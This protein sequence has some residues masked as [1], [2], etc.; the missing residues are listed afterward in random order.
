M[1]LSSPRSIPEPSTNERQ[2]L[3]C[4]RNNTPDGRFFQNFSLYSTEH[5]RQS[6]VR[7]SQSSE[8]D[9][10]LAALEPNDTKIHHHHH[11]KQT[12]NNS[13]ALNVPTKFT[14]TDTSSRRK[15]RP[16]TSSVTSIA[17]TNLHPAATNSYFAPQP[18]S[19]NLEARSPVLKRAPASRS[20]HGIETSS[21]PPPALS[22]QRSYTTEASRN[23]HAS[24]QQRP[25]KPRT[26]AGTLLVAANNIVAGD[27]GSRGCEV[28]TAASSRQK[29]FPVERTSNRMDRNDADV[30]AGDD[31]DATIRAVA[32]VGCGEYRIT[33]IEMLKL[34]IQ[35][36][37]SGNDDLFLRLARSNT[38]SQKAGDAAARSERRKSRIELGRHR[39]SLSTN[40]LP[41]SGARPSSSGR[42]FESR[43]STSFQTRPA[44]SDGWDRQQHSASSQA[45]SPKPDYRFLQLDGPSATSRVQSRNDSRSQ[46]QGVALQ[47]SFSAAHTVSNGS[48]SPESRNGRETLTPISKS[49]PMHAHSYRQSNLSYS[50]LGNGK[51][52]ELRGSIARTTGDESSP[53][54]PRADGTE[55]TASTTA[56]S[57][58]WDE[59]DDL[60]SRIRK[61]ELTGKLPT[62]SGEAVTNG[63]GERPPTA[64]TTV[65]TL[66]PSPKH[67]RGNS[68]SPSPSVVGGPAA[69][70]IH[71]LLHAS[72]AKAKPIIGS[73]AHRALEATA[74]DALSLATMMGSGGPQGT[75]SSAASI[76]GGSSLSERQ[77]R[78]KADS[79]CRSLTELCIAICDL[80]TESASTPARAQAVLQAPVLNPSA[81]P[82]HQ[83][84]DLLT[85]RRSHLES[86]DPDPSTLTRSGSRALSRLEARRSSMQALHTSTTAQSP[87]SEISTPTQDNLKRPKRHSLAPTLLPR[88]RA[89]VNEEDIND[90]EDSPLRPP[91]RALTSIGQPRNS[92]RTPREYTSR[93][94]LPNH[95]PPSALTNPQARRHHVSPSFAGSP[96]VPASPLIQSGARRYLERSTP[97]L[98]ERNP[99]PSSAVEDGPGGN[100]AEERKRRIGSLGQYSPAGRTGE[101]ALGRNGSVIRRSVQGGGGG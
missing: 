97:L 10:R 82:K 23:S 79:M 11:P 94:P 65:T 27:F 17:S 19:S 1:L 87:L 81:S 83:P 93:H 44:T 36:A 67:R 59:L 88:H 49:A 46:K 68:S 20:S 8:R 31:G 75:L 89:L 28:E 85:Y 57:T 99:P 77:I 95:T 18:E 92:P 35:Q 9:H 91:S 38:S 62:T 41:S 26:D 13:T 24:T 2:F 63:S 71:P 74:S 30:W 40:E 98:T 14:P 42:P 43:G 5:A 66:S 45:G 54:I 80:K 61:L 21:G 84:P 70:N 64:T 53:E 16:S 33:S 3:T 72:L 6:S 22:T 51:S 69:A 52:A 32:S 90:D 39:Q 76:V 58:V 47:N 101:V 25:L 29:S 78:R 100:L 48:V 4:E 34:E 60:K 50:T 96:Q 86:Q 73:E 12:S 7:S 56:P 15:R 37:H 55:S